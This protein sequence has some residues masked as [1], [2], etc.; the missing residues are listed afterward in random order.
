MGTF[1]TTKVMSWIASHLVQNEFITQINGIS[2]TIKREDKLHPFISGNKFRKLKYNFAHYKA[3]QAK[4]VATFGGAFSNH[5]AATAAAGK[6]EGLPTI[7]F[8]RGDEL[9]LKSRN[10][11]LTFCEAQGMQLY[12][13]SRDAYREKAQA[14]L[15]QTILAENKYAL[16]AEGGTNALAVKGCEEI[17]LPEDK[18]FDTIAVAVGTGGTFMGLLK[19]SSP[20]QQLLGFDVVH[21]E[22]VRQWIE[23]EAPDQSN[24][25]LLKATQGG[26]YGKATNELVAFINSFY[27]KHQILLDPIYTGKLLFGIFA[28]IKQDQWRWGKNILIIHTGGIQSIAGFNQQQ[29]TKGRPLIK[30]GL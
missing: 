22:N 7:G 19:A 14:T 15:V 5:L 23:K 2:I 17:L 28:L 10:A 8:V 3:I 26:R 13:L 21:D 18:A 1:A 29:K 24:F 16:L 30:V 25:N 20:H 4:G 27:E 9:A 11:T 12:F 6:L